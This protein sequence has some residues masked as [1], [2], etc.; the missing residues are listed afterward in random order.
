MKSPLSWE[1]YFMTLAIV[2]SLKSKDQSTQVG[3]VIVD[4]HTRKV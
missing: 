3:A 2:A 1:E 4:N